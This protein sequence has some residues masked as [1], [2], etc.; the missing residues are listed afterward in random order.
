MCQ[1]MCVTLLIMPETRP[2]SC[3][4]HERRHSMAD[5]SSA[6]S[7]AVTQVSLEPTSHPF[8]VERGYHIATCQGKRVMA[9]V[10]AAEGGGLPWAAFARGCPGC[11]E[12]KKR[13]KGEEEGGELLCRPFR[14]S[15]SL[16]SRGKRLYGAVCAAAR[17]SS[18]PPS[19]LGKRAD[20]G[21]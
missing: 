5:G 4:Y 8:L 3:G 12:A 11:S 6:L 1:S 16:R 14:A 13:G 7:P 21:R 19:E 2:L 15:R 9:R 10:F 18:A 17:R 20:I